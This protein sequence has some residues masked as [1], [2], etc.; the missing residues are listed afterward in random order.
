MAVP[1]V[2]LHH[3]YIMSRKKQQ[4]SIYDETSLAHLPNRYIPLWIELRNFFARLKWEMYEPAF[5]EWFQDG[6]TVVGIAVGP[7]PSDWHAWLEHDGDE[8]AGQFWDTIEHPERTIPG[9]W[10]E[11]DSERLGDNHVRSRCL[12]EKL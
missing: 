7:K 4:H 3:R 5:H 2:E 12:G 1:I 6:L 9:A 11:D 10:F 8:Y